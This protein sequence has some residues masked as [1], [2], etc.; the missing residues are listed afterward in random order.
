M[1]QILIRGQYETLFV[2]CRFADEHLSKVAT[3]FAGV[4]PCHCLLNIVTSGLR[5]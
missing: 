1:L 5:L 3:C 4:L 2:D